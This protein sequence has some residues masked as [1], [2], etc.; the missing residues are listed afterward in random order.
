M[1]AE[2]RAPFPTARDRKTEEREKGQGYEF[3]K[4]ESQ[5]LLC[6]NFYSGSSTNS[7]QLGNLIFNSVVPLENGENSG[8]FIESMIR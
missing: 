2:H 5:R 3:K 8:D 4:N 7:L 1:T 6:I